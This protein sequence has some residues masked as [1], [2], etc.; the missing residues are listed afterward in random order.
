MPAATLQLG[1]LQR[2]KSR[3]HCQL[4]SRAFDMQRRAGKSHSCTI[5]ATG[6]SPKFNLRET[7]ELHARDHLKHDWSVLLKI[8]KSRR[9]IPE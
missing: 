5:P 6:A 2:A 4:T 8:P 9:T 3:E 7:L 1:S